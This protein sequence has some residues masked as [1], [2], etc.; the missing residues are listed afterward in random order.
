M[1]LIKFKWSY[2]D[3][4]VDAESGLIRAKKSDDNGL[5]MGKPRGLNVV[6]ALS[7]VIVWYRTM[8][9]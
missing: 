2:D 6:G 4:M 5:P 9:A 3:Y 1:L 8:G 7:L